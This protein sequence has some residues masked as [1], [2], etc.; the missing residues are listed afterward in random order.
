MKLPPR[1]IW[2]RSDLKCG[3]RQDE[4]VGMSEAHTLETMIPDELP[5]LPL[6]ELVVFPHM[7][8]PIVVAREASKAAVE[9]ALAADRLLLLVA[10]RDPDEIEPDPDDL[11][12]VGTVVNLTG[13]SRLPDGRIKI[14]VQGVARARIESVIDQE[15]TLWVRSVALLD[16][17]TE[18]DWSV[19]SEALM[20]S[21]RSHVEQLLDFFMGKILR[22]LLTILLLLTA[23]MFG[24][25]CNI[26]FFL[27]Q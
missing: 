14:L 15:G 13:R 17:E 1:A 21:V 10:Q 6:R 23:S 25:R 26:S 11:Y 22:C 8:L 5:V 4:I 3:R 20:R 19:E 16:H 2:G 27:A 9:D 12:R 24:I 7:A 18:E